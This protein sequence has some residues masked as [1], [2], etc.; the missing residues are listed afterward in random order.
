MK[1]KSILFVAF[2]AIVTFIASTNIS[3]AESVFPIG[4]KLDNFTMPAPDGKNHSYND[5]KGKKGTLIIFLSAQCPV[6]KM[7]DDRI[8]EIAADYKAKGINFIGIYSNHTESNEWVKSHSEEKYK[9]PVLIDKN[10]VFADKLGASFT[11]EVYFFNE[12]NV[13][14]YHGAIDND[15]Y[16]KSISKEYLKTAF[17]Q[18]LSG[19]EISEKDTNAFGCT[20]KRVEKA[21]MK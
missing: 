18:N 15:K 14:D 7:Y 5:L 21:E 1:R 8:N 17:D 6:V 11:P 10:N 4:S 9:F 13:L 19:K 20:I 3:N 12:K 16:G 2:L